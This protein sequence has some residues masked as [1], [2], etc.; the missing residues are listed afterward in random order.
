M[1]MKV[2]Q[3]KPR[4]KLSPAIRDGQKYVEV[5][6][7]EDD[8]DFFVFFTGKG[9]DKPANRTT[10]ADSPPRTC[11]FPVCFPLYLRPV[12]FENQ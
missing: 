6:F 9:G 11:R 10:S 8:M 4:I 12:S 3:S 7:D 5:E 2:Y 1:R